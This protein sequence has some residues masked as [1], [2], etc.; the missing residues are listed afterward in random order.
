[1]DVEL[2]DYITS[3]NECFE[4]N[5]TRP[6]RDAAQEPVFSE[7]FNPDFTHALFGNRQEIIGYK[8]PTIQLSFRANDMK[9]SLQAGFEEKVELR[10]EVYSE[11]H[12][13]VDFKTMFKEYLPAFVFDRSETPAESAQTDPTSK[14]WRPPGKQLHTFTLHGKQFEIW[15][16]SFTDPAV[17][18]L[19][20]NIRILPMLFIDGA[21]LPELDLEW[22]LERWSIYLL[23]EVTPIDD[24]IS[25]YTLAGFSTTYRLWLL[26]TFEI[27]R[28][29]KSLPSPPASTNSD[30]SKWTPPRLTQDPETFRIKEH[31]NSLE[32]PSR[33]RIS[34]FLI[35]P[36]FQGQSLGATLYE[37]IFADLVKRSYI[38]ELTVEE[39]SEEFDAMRDF[40]D[41]VYLRT[42]PSFLSLTIPATISKEKLAKSAPIPRDEILGNLNIRQLQRETKIVPRQFN[43]M[44]ELHLLSTIPP[45]NRNKNR[46][47]RKDKCSNENDRRY[48]FWRL[49]VK[50]RIFCQNR[51]QL[52]TMEEGEEALTH[53]QKVDMV[54]KAV[55]RQ[56]E[57]YEERLQGLERR[58]K[59]KNGEVK[60]GSSSRSKRKRMVVE[61]DEDDE[62]EDMNDESVSSKRARV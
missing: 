8:E 59:W 53:A 31:I 57:E 16:A 38:Y 39:P 49:A 54:E 21:S 3:A 51:D 41:I 60:E 58:T 33:E 30:A 27:M 36:P 45:A 26:P 7:S 23:Y 56:Q 2:H 11:R 6:S 44:L 14:D 19:W 35:L 47:T 62:W 22:S 52:V 29:T 20:D 43:R 46:I 17:R 40:S 48:Y 5:L 50:D 9:P 37:T 28:A 4:L 55:S 15:V 18:N 13:K 61:D 12:L 42:L 25:P 34:Q 32:Q 1:M 10:E 24:E